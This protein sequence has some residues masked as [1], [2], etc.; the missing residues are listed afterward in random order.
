MLS[1]GESQARSGAEL[2]LLPHRLSNT[3]G[4]R[5]PSPIPHPLCSV[6][7]GFFFFPSHNNFILKSSTFLPGSHGHMLSHCCHPLL[8]QDDPILLALRAWST[9]EEVYLEMSPLDP[10]AE[11]LTVGQDPS[12]LHH[13]NACQLISRALSTCPAGISHVLMFPMKVGLT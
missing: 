7:K 13:V 10:A 6:C 9:A 4:F 8:G 2:R 3:Y 5:R 12:S 1:E 11:P